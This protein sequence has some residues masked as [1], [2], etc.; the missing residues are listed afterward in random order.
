MFFAKS[1]GVAELRQ[2]HHSQKEHPMKTFL[3]TAVMAI[4]TTPVM[5]QNW[6]RHPTA[7]VHSTRMDRS[8]HLNDRFDVRHFNGPSAYG[9]S[10]S[11]WSSPWLSHGPGNLSNRDRL[12]LFHGN[13]RRAAPV[14]HNHGGTHGQL[15]GG[16][17]D[18]GAFGF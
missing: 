14:R 3:L 4:V 9:N 18:H 10:S 2:C 11:N 7:Q 15:N 6:N 5:A 13:I 1:G 17:W 12:D 8:I 16:Q